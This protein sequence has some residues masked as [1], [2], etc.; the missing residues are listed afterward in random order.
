MERNGQKQEET[1]RNGK[2]WE[3]SQK[4]PKSIRKISYRAKNA[5]KRPPKGHLKATE[6]SP[7]DHQ[8]S[9]K[10]HQK[11]TKRSPKG[12]QKDLKKSPKGHQKVTKR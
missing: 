10:D 12:H 5:T 6:R 3:V 7:K 9:P 11:V 4:Y 8:R 1:G 2:E